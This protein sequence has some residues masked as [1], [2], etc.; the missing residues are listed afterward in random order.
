M[1]NGKSVSVI[2]MTYRERDSIRA[3]ID[4]FL[5][6]GLVDEV[7]V[8]DNNAEPGTAEEVAKTRARRVVETQQG[9][10]WASRRGLQ[11]ATGD[12]L[13]LAEPDGTFKP[14]DIIKL[15]AYSTACDAVL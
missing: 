10:G 8:I 3:V 2:L 12:L 9:Y 1:W 13:V 6:T 11:D 7:L 14:A 5:A 4:G 15:L